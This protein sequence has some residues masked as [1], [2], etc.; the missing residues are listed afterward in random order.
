MKMEE[1]VR[2]PHT[3]LT[4]LC[5]LSE[6]QHLPGLSGFWGDAVRCGESAANRRISV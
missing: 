5:D 1:M 2:F 4:G 6:T 3:P